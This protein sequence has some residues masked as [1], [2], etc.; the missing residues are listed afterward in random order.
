MYF[1]FSRWS[2]LWVPISKVPRDNENRGSGRNQRSLSL[3][4]WATVF[5]PIS[6]TEGQRKYEQEEIEERS[7]QLCSVMAGTGT[8]MLKA[9]K[10]PG[11]RRLMENRKTHKTKLE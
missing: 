8:G 7:V 3:K 4:S 6:R 5:T 1:T 2:S 11:V 9:F 10:W